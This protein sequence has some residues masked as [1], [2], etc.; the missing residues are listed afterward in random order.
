MNGVEPY[1]S[2]VFYLPNE[3]CTL[4]ILPDVQTPYTCLKQNL[5]C[6]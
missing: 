4:I 5:K 6:Q 2:V 1:K 3:Q